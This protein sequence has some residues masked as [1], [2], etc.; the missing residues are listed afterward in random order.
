MIQDKITFRITTVFF[1]IFLFFISS[2]L[3]AE[4]VNSFTIEG[5]SLGDSALQYYS[6]DQIKKNTRDHFNDKNI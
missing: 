6:E 3:Y 2:K 4:S 5:I 1:F